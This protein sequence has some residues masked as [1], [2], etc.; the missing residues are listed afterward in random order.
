MLHSEQIIRDSAS[1]ADGENSVAR[2]GRGDSSGSSVSGVRFGSGFSGAVGGGVR[3]ERRREVEEALR[4]LLLLTARRDHALH[5][6]LGLTAASRHSSSP[7]KAQAAVQAL[8]DLGVAEGD[9]ALQVLLILLRPELLL[10]RCV[11]HFRL[12]YSTPCTYVCVCVCVLAF[13]FFIVAW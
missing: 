5:R 6:A 2:H 13:L 4:C 11:L 9:T 3:A 10:F 7:R 8:F 12:L 1:T